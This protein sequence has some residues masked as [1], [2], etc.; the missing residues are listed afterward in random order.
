MAHPEVPRDEYKSLRDEMV[1]LFNRA[2]VV[3]AAEIAAFTTLAWRGLEAGPASA[4]WLAFLSQLLLL[5]G[6]GLSLMLYQ[7]I[8]NIG[9][10]IL[11]FHESGKAEGA[12]GRSGWHARRRVFRLVTDDM[13]GH[14]YERL[15]ETRT[16]SAAYG[17]ILA[18]NVVLGLRGLPPDLINPSFWPTIQAVGLWALTGLCAWL[19]WALAQ[20]YRSGARAWVKRWREFAAKFGSLTG[21]KLADWLLAEPVRPPASEPPVLPNTGM[22]SDGA[23]Q[24]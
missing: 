11:V 1:Q 3:L 21:E 18:A 17:V 15:T 5:A 8:Y 4:F 24:S 10:Y 9:S 12:T 13:G 7:H 6:L 19:L 23:A 14:W 2:F 22:K 20:T 16:T